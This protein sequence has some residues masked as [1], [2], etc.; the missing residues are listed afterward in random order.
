MNK[1]FHPDKHTA[2][3]KEL[4]RTKKQKTQNQKTRGK[5]KK[6]KKGTQAKGN[7]QHIGQNQK[8]KALVVG[9]FGS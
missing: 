6:P 4:R 5:T 8:N 7:G 2:A 9:P 3:L 1:R